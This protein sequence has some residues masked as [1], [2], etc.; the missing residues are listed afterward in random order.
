M[1]ALAG[2]LG[3]EFFD[4]KLRGLCM[5]W[6][7][8]HVYAIREA[9]TLNM[10][11]L[12]EQFGAP[13]AEQ[14]IIPMILVMSRNKNYLHSKYPCMLPSSVSATD[15]N[16]YF[17]PLGMTCLFCLNVL[18]EVC[19]TDITTKLLLPTV[20]LL[21]ADPVA[22][23]RFNVAKTLQKISPFLEASVIDSQVKPMLDKLNADTD[24][25]VKH[26]AAQAIAG[27]AAGKN[28]VLVETSVRETNYAHKHY[29][30][31]TRVKYL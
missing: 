19:G 17:L 21:A 3:Q 27:I 16:M 11:K 9:A 23:V 7:N 2:Q 13:W 18:A 15:V 20:L 24:V 10:K 31:K 26:F 6:L 4:Q 5:G 12:V 25:D 29:S 22:N 30:D 1:P 14:A 8:D 28:K